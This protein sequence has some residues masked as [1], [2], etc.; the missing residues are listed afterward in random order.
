[1]IRSLG[2]RFS[3]VAERWVPDPFAIALALTVVTF[4][5]AWAITGTDPLRLLGFWGG[6]LEGDT[7]TP[8]ES[9][10]W[11]LIAF[12]M[13]MCLILVTGYALASTTAV[14]ALIN[15]IARLPRSNAS[16]IAI[17]AVTAM[18]AAWINWGLGLIV[19]ALVARDVG[20]NALERGVK[21]HYPLIGAAGYTGLMVWHGGL[22]GTAPFK[23]TQAKDIA[24][25]LPGVQ[26]APIGLDQTVFSLLNLAVSLA[27]LIAVP[28]ILIRLAPPEDRRVPFDPALLPAEEAPPAPR[29]GPAGWLEGSRLLA[30]LIG[31][32]A[33]GYLARYLGRVGWLRAD[34]NAI[35]L[36]FLALGLI[37][38]QRPIAYAR[39]IS[40]AASGCAGIILQFPFY[41]GIMALMAASGLI[42]I[43]AQGFATVATE[44][45]FGPLTFLSAGVVNLFVPSGGGQWSVQG[46]IVMQTADALGVDLGKAVLAFA[47]GDGWTNMLQPFWALPLLAITGLKAREIV[48]Y[49]L[50]LML[51]VTPIYVGALMVF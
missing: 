47:Y 3:R 2:E 41:A 8:A 11:R 30:W 32:A 36:L 20:R 7:V 51:L 50:A 26:V 13:Q 44:T 49:T 25:L 37:L 27:L 45:S 6:R 29:G 19:G 39:A 14:R 28:L 35:N 16:A 18:L 31:F 43:T 15:R 12:G 9:G 38:H 48:G 33:L 42:A 10:L 5:L 4:G 22:S 17:T 23:V 24:E 40:Q 21:V 1:M 34:V 46:A